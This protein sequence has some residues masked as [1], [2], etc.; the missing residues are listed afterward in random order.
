MEG[1]GKHR[2]TQTPD[3]AD[4]GAVFE[5]V[6]SRLKGLGFRGPP[7]QAPKHEQ[8][9][10]AVTTTNPRPQTPNCRAFSILR[11]EI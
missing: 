7:P 5:E 4:L 8:I 10:P 6:R 1:L 2:R 3:L 11:L 9:D